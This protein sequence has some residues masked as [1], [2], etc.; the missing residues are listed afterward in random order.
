MHEK[1][2]IPT[3]TEVATAFGTV[4]RRRRQAL[5]LTQEQVAEASQVSTQY[6]SLMER[7]V[8]QPSL[9]TLIMV[10]RALDA[11]IHSVLTDTLHSLSAA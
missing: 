6:V 1:G 3:K 8:H 2:A 11:D 10:A 7:G 4:L 5:G 9:H